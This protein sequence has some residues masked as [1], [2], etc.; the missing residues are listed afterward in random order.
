M[1]HLSKRQYKSDENLLAD[2]VLLKLLVSTSQLVSCRRSTIISSLVWRAGV[3]TKVKS[4]PL[5]PPQ[6]HGSLYAAKKA[7]S[8]RK[9]KRT[10]THITHAGGRHDPVV[11]KDIIAG[12]L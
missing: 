1:L 4:P 11:P 2:A 9:L 3:S 7:E 5:L 12:V 6:F 10:S 8:V